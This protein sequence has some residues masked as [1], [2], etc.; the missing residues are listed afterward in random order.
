MGIFTHKPIAVIVSCF[1]D[2]AR[3]QLISHTFSRMINVH[4]KRPRQFLAWSSLSAHALCPSKCTHQ[5]ATVEIR[6]ANLIGFELKGIHDTG[7][8]GTTS[9]PMPAGSRPLDYL[10]ELGKG[11]FGVVMEAKRCHDHKKVAACIHVRIESLCRIAHHFVRDVFLFWL[12][13]FSGDA[14]GLRTWGLQT[15]MVWGGVIM[16]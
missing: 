11:S 16:C 12:Y 14:S 9:T 8:T 13:S 5:V 7:S 4:T 15:D 10:R 3:N 1:L 2:P 6:L